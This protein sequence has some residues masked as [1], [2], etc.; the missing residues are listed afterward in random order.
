MTNSE[1]EV[2]GHTINIK[3]CKGR[4][5]NGWFRAK[6]GKVIV[7]ADKISISMSLE[8]SIIDYNRT[9]STAID[10]LKLSIKELE[11]RKIRGLVDE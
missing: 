5:V 6:N 3:P 4:I 9:I 1:I 2:W 11:S 10:S 8:E 7:P